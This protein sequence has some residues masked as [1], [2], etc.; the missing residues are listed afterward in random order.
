M[1][2]AYVPDGKSNWTY[3]VQVVTDTGES[4]SVEHT[5][6]VDCL[7]ICTIPFYQPARWNDFLTVRSRNNCYNYSNDE[8][9][10]TFAQ[11]GR[12]CGEQWGEISCTAIMDAAI[13]DGL[14]LLPDPQGAC[15]AGTHKVHVV[16]APRWDFHFYRQDDNGVWSH[17]LGGGLATDL[18]NS[19]Q[20]ITDP[21]LADTGNYTDHCGYLC[22]C[23]DCAEIQ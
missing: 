6:N 9:T 19:G 22:A 13:C 4:S 17:K 8:V 21:E 3:M 7:G 1:I 14:A 16:V 11:P 12:A 18:D 23:G 10:M 15:P 5:V 20:L 2:E